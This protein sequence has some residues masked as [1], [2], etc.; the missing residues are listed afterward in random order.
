MIRTIINYVPPI[1]GKNNFSEVANNYSA[2]KRE[3]KSFK[4]LM[5]NLENFAKN[6]ADG[7]LYEQI[8]EN[9]KALLPNHQQV[10]VHKAPIDRLLQEIIEILSD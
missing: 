6:T 7:F 8:K 1:F 9:K 3:N 10:E 2:E 5:S 4:N